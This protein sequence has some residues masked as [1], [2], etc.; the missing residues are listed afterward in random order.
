MGSLVIRIVEYVR[1]S[2]WLIP[3]GMVAAATVLGYLFIRVD[4]YYG[5]DIPDWLKASSS[6]GVRQ[7]L[8]TVSGA[9][10]TVAGVSFSITVV[11]LSLASQQFGPRLLRNF[12]RDRGNQIILGTFL[13]TFIYCL[14]V[15][16]S[17][18][19]QD[20][21]DFIPHVSVAFAMVLTLL[22]VGA[23]IWFFHHFASSIVV[24]RVLAHVADELTWAI[25]RN[26]PCEGTDAAAPG[27]QPFETAT[28][29]TARKQ[30]YVLGVNI[31]QLLQLASKHDLMIEVVAS[32]GAFVFF[33]APVARIAGKHLAD[34]E[35]PDAI[36]D[37]FPLGTHRT[38]T[39][40]ID[41]A[42]SQIVEVALRA[43]SPSLNDPNTA[44]AAIDRLAGGLMRRAS[45][46][47]PTVWRAT[48]DGKPRLLT[49][50]VSWDACV[51]LAF[52]RIIHSGATLTVVPTHVLLTLARLIA[53]V[54]AE[55]RDA[56]VRL[57]EFARERGT[58]EAASALEREQIEQAWQTVAGAIA[59]CT[60]TAPRD[61]LAV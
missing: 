17:V 22:S 36:R 51:E 30:G 16:R 18:R 15:L 59:Q 2:L 60:S 47:D 3:T 1:L 7:L 31:E 6:E 14:V 27:G 39:Q 49:T 28:V 11:G 57:A 58:A 61:V 8:A 9:M 20:F 19:G 54:P 55:R 50:P 44:I 56:L 46:A 45:A 21:G 25:D 37:A 53:A 32:P 5:G 12:M 41:F 4:R 52:V 24:E 42:I 23:L 40:D 29:V 43:L 13:S 48:S 38:P 10:I 35:L 26:Y 34:P 33:G